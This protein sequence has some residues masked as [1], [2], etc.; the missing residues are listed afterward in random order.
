M[1]PLYQGY[2]DINSE[3]PNDIVMYPLGSFYEVLG[4]GAEFVANTL[5]LRSTY[6]NIGYGDE[7]VPMCGFPDHVLKQYTQKLLDSGRNVVVVS[8][9]DGERKAHLIRS[10]ATEPMK[11]VVAE[12]P[13]P[14][15]A[16]AVA[17][18]TQS[19]IDT[20]LLH[21]NGN[22]DSK[23]RVLA[24][25]QDHNRERGTADWLKNE[26]GGTLSAFTVTKSDLSVE[27][28]WAKVQRHI[29]QLVAKGAF[30]SL[31][32]AEQTIVEAVPSNA[33]DITLDMYDTQ[34]PDV[35]KVKEN[36]YLVT[37]E[38]NATNKL[39]ERFASKGFTPKEDSEH[40]L[41]FETDGKDW[42]RFFLFP[43]PTATSGTISMP[44]MCLPPRKSILCGR[45]YK[46]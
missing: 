39:W 1:T 45:W 20:A 28:P 43:T 3:Y 12:Q 4:D 2:L 21:W 13:I 14:A 8:V 17:K 29:G 36:S 27:L 46:R 18:I 16:E 23:A 32:E 6:R 42:N 24:Y 19:D 33:V 9:E 31:G 26:Y 30:T 40:R 41:V 11:E 25:M 38:V 44:L 37:V 5:D 34:S 22:E 7:R 10:T 35:F 15:P